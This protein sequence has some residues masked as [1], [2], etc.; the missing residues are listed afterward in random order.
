MELQGMQ[1]GLKT[2]IHEAIDEKVESSGGNNTALLD[3]RLGELEKR[4]VEKLDT[5]E[6]FQSVK[7]LT[8]VPMCPNFVDALEEP[9]VAMC[10]QFC[11]MVSLG[12]V[13]ESFCL[14]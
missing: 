13:L 7:S 9:I 8:S 10:N 5:L 11:I 1:E 14:P 6:K 2:I 3:K 4:L 12:A